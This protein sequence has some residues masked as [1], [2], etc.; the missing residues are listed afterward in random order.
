MSMQSI[1]MQSLQQA[2]QGT[3]QAVGK[4]IRQNKARIKFNTNIYLVDTSSK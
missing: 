3:T 4:A 1:A 2:L